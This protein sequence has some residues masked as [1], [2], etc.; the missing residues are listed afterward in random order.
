[1]DIWTW[2]LFVVQ[3]K[4]LEFV[5]DLLLQGNSHHVFQIL[6]CVTDFIYGLLGIKDELNLQCK[7]CVPLLYSL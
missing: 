1:M 6:I 5:C 2:T 7:I 3:K 4:K